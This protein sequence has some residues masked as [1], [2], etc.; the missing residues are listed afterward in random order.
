[1]PHA[2]LRS[3][4]HRIGRQHHLDFALAAQSFFEQVKRLGHAPSLLRQAAASD[5]APHGVQQLIG[6]QRIGGGCA[7]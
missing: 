3:R 6:E 5:R 4:P 2:R 7:T 1:M